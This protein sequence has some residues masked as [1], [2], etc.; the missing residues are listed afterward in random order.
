MLFHSFLLTV[1]FCS[2]ACQL[3]SKL[4][5]HTQVKEIIANLLPPTQ[6]LFNF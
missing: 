2:S 6:L 5:V 1:S 3:Q 4:L